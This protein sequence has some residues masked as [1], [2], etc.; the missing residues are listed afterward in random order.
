MKALR[1]AALT[2]WMVTGAA[3]VTMPDSLTVVIFDY[4]GVPRTALASAVK[5]AR[6]AFR[7]AGVETNWVIC[8]ATQGCYV[9][10]RFMQVKILPRPIRNTPV[11]HHGLAST[12]LCSTDDRCAASYLFYDRI[13][14]FA[15]N[16]GAPVGITLGYVMAHEVGHLMGL[17]H[18]SGGIMNAGFTSRNLH[19]AETG[20]LSFAQEDA[21]ELRAAVARSQTAGEPARE[22]KTSARRA[23]VAE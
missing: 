19:D 14:T 23:G 12:A 15:D 2:L 21:R 6:Y 5:E 13:L 4:A 1:A 3:G 20:W 9:P 22:L 17:G 10:E 7:A 8:G 11:S 18:R 16:A